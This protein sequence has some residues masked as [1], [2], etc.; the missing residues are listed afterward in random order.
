MPYGKLMR[1]WKASVT[2][3]LA[4][5][6]TASYS[7]VLSTVTGLEQRFQPVDHQWTFAWWSVSKAAQKS[8]VGEIKL[9]YIC[10]KLNFTC[11]STE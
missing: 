7:R 6:T 4:L 9:L 10:F 5:G 1:H 11:K 3:K 8:F 2:G